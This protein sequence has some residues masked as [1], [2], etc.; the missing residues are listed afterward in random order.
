MRKRRIQTVLT[1]R[2]RKLDLPWQQIADP[3]HRPVLYMTDDVTQPRLGVNAV[4]PAGDDQRVEDR[5]TFSA[6][7]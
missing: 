1:F 7:I 2:Q 3:V 5:R 4:K 6:C